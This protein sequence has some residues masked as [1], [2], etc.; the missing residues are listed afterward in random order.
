MRCR[1]AAPVRGLNAFSMAHHSSFGTS[2]LRRGETGGTPRSNADGRGRWM[3]HFATGPNPLFASN[4]HA[5]SD[6]QGVPPARW[7]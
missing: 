5:L 3:L 1:R 7:R 6:G 2:C 4:A